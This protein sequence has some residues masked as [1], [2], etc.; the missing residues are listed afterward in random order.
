ML[1]SRFHLGRVFPNDPEGEERRPQRGSHRRDVALPHL[2]AQPLKGLVLT[3][4]AARHAEAVNGAFLSV[5]VPLGITC[6]RDGW[7]LLRG[8]TSTTHGAMGPSSARAWAL[9]ALWVSDCAVT[10][11]ARA[12]PRHSQCR[13]ICSISAVWPPLPGADSERKKQLSPFRCIHASHVAEKVQHSPS[14]TIMTA[15]DSRLSFL[16]PCASRCTAHRAQSS[17]AAPR[18]DH[19]MRSMQ[20][21]A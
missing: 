6:A 15:A 17:A 1:P 5:H 3:A 7:H 16:G 2:P 8:M 21:Q 19:M 18:I 9:A 10:K 20:S 14:T 4:L 13:S 12:T 11:T